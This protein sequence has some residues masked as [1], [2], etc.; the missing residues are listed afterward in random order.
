MAAD[1]TVPVESKTSLTVNKDGACV[2]NTGDIAMTLYGYPDSKTGGGSPFFSYEVMV[3][4]KWVKRQ[5][6]WCGTGA[7][8]F[9]LAENKSQ[10]FNVYLGYYK[11]RPIRVTV[12]YKNAAGD[13]KIITSNQIDEAFKE[14]KK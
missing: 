6:G 10:K 12:N 13:T 8:A 3:D 9:T 14:E 7:S 1:T 2:L 11:E 4:K 5:L